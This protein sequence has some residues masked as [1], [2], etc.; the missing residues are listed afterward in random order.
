MRIL[1]ADP[2]RRKIGPKTGGRYCGA[3]DTPQPEEAAKSIGV[4]RG[5]ANLE[6]ARSWHSLGNWLAMRQDNQN[7]A[8]RDC[9]LLN[10]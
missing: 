2:P 1:P 5:Q 7:Q 9:N 6:P 3:A 10:S 8:N 4:G